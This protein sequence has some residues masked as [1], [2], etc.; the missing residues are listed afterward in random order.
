MHRNELGGKQDH[1]NDCR[2]NQAG[3]AE[4]I[5]RKSQGGEQLLKQAGAVSEQGEDAKQG[6]Q[7]LGGGAALADAQTVISGSSGIKT[8][9]GEAGQ[10]RL[11]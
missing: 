1:R 4:E 5:Q 2:G 11:H 9:S 10:Q 6:Q 3:G 8:G 7:C